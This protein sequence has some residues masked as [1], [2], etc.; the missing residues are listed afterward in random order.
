LKAVETVKAEKTSDSTA[1]ATYRFKV[2]PEYLN[3]A[4]GIQ[5]GAV[6][7]FFDVATSWT[8]FVISKPGFWESSGTSRTLNTTYLRPAFEGEVLIMETEV[9]YVVLSA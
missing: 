5:G 9:G 3:P 7:T 1:R 4:M 6:A 2:L 8:L